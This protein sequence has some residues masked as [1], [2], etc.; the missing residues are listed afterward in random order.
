MVVWRCCLDTFGFLSTPER[1]IKKCHQ[2]MLVRLSAAAREGN[3]IMCM[4]FF[5]RLHVSKREKKRE[6]AGHGA[7]KGARDSR[8]LVSGKKL[9]ESMYQIQDRI[10][11]T[12]H[13]SK[14]A[15]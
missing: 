8:S 14:A 11:K 15:R 13:D 10:F 3:L 9:S 1:H 6:G 4:Q 5:I 2:R 7:G 12:A